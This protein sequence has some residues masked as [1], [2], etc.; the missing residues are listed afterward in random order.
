MA[1]KNKNINWGEEENRKREEAL[2]KERALEKERAINAINEESKKKGKWSRRA[3]IVG[4][5][6]AG[7][8]LLVGIAGVAGNMYVNKAI[9]KYSA[10][11]MGEG[12]SMNAWIR[13]APD[14]TITMAVPRAEMGQGVYTSLPMLLAE[15]LEVDMNQ[16]EIV[17][18]QPES[19]YA[20]T[21]FLDP[22][23]RKAYASYSMMAKVA[24]FL[25]V[26]GTGGSTS[27]KDLYDHLREM[28]AT[29]R[30][31]LIAAA[32]E[33]WGVKASDCYAESAYVINK[34]TK[35]RLSYGS[36][37]EAAAKV[38]LDF[39]P[40][41]KAQKDFK[42]L[43]K[44]VQR[45]DIPEKVT[46]SA[47]FGID[48]RPEGMLVAA[49][50]HA[51]YVGGTVNGVTNEE[52]VLK[53]RGVQKVVLLENGLGAAVVADNTWRAKNAAMALDLEETANTLENVSSSDISKML[54]DIIA[55]DSK[56]IGK[57]EAHG[58]VKAALG[59]DAKVV[60]A[61][62][63]VP[64]LSQC[65]ME[66]LNCT[67]VINGDKCEVWVGHQGG[68]LVRDAVNAV[69]EIP[70][71]NIK[72]NITYLGGGFGR[73][74]E[75]DFVKKAAMVAKQMPG[76]P[77]QLVF[78]R[79]EDMK[80]GMYRPAVASTF[81]GT[82]GADGM[83]DAWDNK[84]AL[85]SVG[86]SSMMRIMPAMAEPPEKDPQSA[87]GAIELPYARKNVSVQFGELDLPALQVGNWRSVGASQNGFFTESFMDELAHEAGE[88]PYEFRK[89]HMEKSDLPDASRYL[90]V[91]NKVASMANWS[92]PLP[93]GKARGISILKSFGSIVGQVA[94]VTKLGDKEIKIDKV[95]CVI[96]CG[97]IV[98][99][100]TVEAQ[101]QSGIIYGLSAA[102]FGEITMT[103]GQID[104]QNFPQYEMVRMKTSPLFKVHIMEVDAYPGGV[105]EPATP[106][107]APAIA[108]AIFAATGERVRSLP[109]IK[110][111]Y[112]FV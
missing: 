110:H 97:R 52:E 67:M 102:L 31:A 14:N 63:E 55:D 35:E 10:A 88:D 37:A 23:P 32:A 68:S 105:G 4:G 26:V 84:M 99:P 107:A 38:D 61:N 83:I 66:P 18:P 76:T 49:I 22:N 45:L 46:G 36:L 98:N 42:L 56:M 103:N 94:E 48:A 82:L 78:T 75:L 80:N 104:Q 79:E 53:M 85:Q 13:I 27:V 25:P 59:G 2:R 17:H 81:K 28:G 77:I 7:V 44:P 15:E 108:N 100:D 54:S 24:A 47:Q 60:E 5:G 29:A 90:A 93:A 74:A 69:T 95:Y 71:D 30:E 19:P 58:D 34:K 40:P 3:F 64:Y 6:L 73:R 8:G 72:V 51:S 87:E 101:M 106:P 65:T 62:Y 86:Y 39:N 16:I 11:G 112:T 21:F 43:G 89:K 92:N 9:K 1:D 96:D 91:L 57:P 33:K 12:A 70:K 20:N 109:L 111:G 41:L 50:R